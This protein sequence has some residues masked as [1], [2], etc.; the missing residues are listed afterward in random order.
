MKRIPGGRLLF[1][2]TPAA[3]LAFVFSLTQSGSGTTLPSPETG[4][5][6]RAQGPSS[7]LSVEIRESSGLAKGRSNPAV[8]WTHND[9]GNDA[10]LFGLDSTGTTVARVP[11]LGT[12]TVD[13]EDLEAGPCE[14]G[15]CLYVADIGDNGRQR[16]SVSIYVVPEPAAGSSGVKPLRHL[17]ARYPDGAQDAEGLFVLPNG[18]VHLV[19]KGRHGEIALYRYP[20]AATSGVATLERVRTLLPRPKSNLDRVTSATAS[21][22]GRWVA[23]RTYRTLYLYPTKALIS[24]SKALPLT[25]DL[26]PLKERQGESVALTDG[27][28]L[29]LTSE[30]KGGRDRPTMVRLQCTLTEGAS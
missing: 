9:S 6:C 3:A 2:A 30:A 23:I 21:P 19:T 25:F 20:R 24:E 15:N 4:E 11:L 22:N 29:W 1:V 16:E 27:G 26:T 10:V 13:W 28:E 5:L 18:Q 7:S 12:T 17:V 8:L 14:D